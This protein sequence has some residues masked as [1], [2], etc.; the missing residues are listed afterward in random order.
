MRWEVE[1]GGRKVSWSLPSPSFRAGG[2]L[3]P[4][5][6]GPGQV[7][8]EEEGEGGPVER[9]RA[10]WGPPQRSRVSR[11]GGCVAVVFGKH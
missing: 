2:G 3:C 11:G 1:K 4:V 7:G 8:A 9:V 5:T 6:G 10:C